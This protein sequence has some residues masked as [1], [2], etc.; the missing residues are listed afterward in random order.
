MTMNN[1]VMKFQA[2]ILDCNVRRPKVQ[3]TTALG[4]AY[5]AGLATGVWSNLE[6]LKKMWGEEKRWEPDMNN[7]E[8]EKL[9]KGWNKAV[10]KSLDWV[11]E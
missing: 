11:E 3:E 7:E 4:A 10:T 5:A 9:W 1:L 6:E 2:D 8:R